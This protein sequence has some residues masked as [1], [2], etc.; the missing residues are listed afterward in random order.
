MSLATG[1]TL[2]P[3]TITAE[4]G[5]GGMG[6]VYTA[7]D[8]RLDRQVAIKVLPPDLT[9]DETA[10]QRFLQE[11]KAASALDHPNICTIFEINETDDGQLYL[12]MAHYEGETLKERIERGA[13]AVDHAVDIATQVGQGLAEAHGAGIVHRDVKPANLLIATNGVVKILDFGLAKLAGTEGVTQTGT[14]VGTVAYMSPE[15]ARGE[16][17]DHRTDIWSLGVVLYE[18]L[19]GT[20]PFQ[21][22]NL[23]A[24]SNAIQEG[25]PSSL[26]GASSSA[27]SVV[28]RA[29][30]A[31]RTQR[32]QA[33]T[34]LLDELRRETGP[35]TQAASPSD[36]PSIAVLPFANMSADPEQEYSCD[37]LAEEL[38]DT[39]ARLEGLKVVARTSAF[40]FKG[41]ADDIRRIGEQLDVA[42]VLEGS[43]RKAGNRLRITAQLIS[44]SDG[45]HLWS[46]RYDRTLDD[47]FAVQEEIAQAIVGKLKVELVGEPDAPLV[48]TSTTNLKAYS[49]H[50][51]GQ[52]HANRL[53]KSGYR[54]AL[55]CFDRA[56]AIEPDYAAAF[57]GRAFVHMARS[58][59][60]HEKPNE[61]VPKAREAAE[62]ALALD[63]E[64]A[65][66]VMSLAVQRFW[67]DWDWVGAERDFQ[68]AIAL[69]P[70]SADA[71]TLYA[72]FLSVRGRSDEA[73]AAAERSLELDPLSLQCNR[74]LAVALLFAGRLDAAAEQCR[75][76]LDLEPSYFPARWHLAQ[77]CAASGRDQD[78]VSVLEAGR[79]EAKGDPLL[80]AQLG[81]FYALT[82]RVAEARGI[83]DAL[84]R[85]RDAGYLPA[86]LIGWVHEGLD[87]PDKALA[88]YEQSYR[89]R[90]GLCVF[91]GLGRTGGWR[92]IRGFSTCCAGSRRARRSS[93]NPRF[94]TLLRRMNFPE[95]ASSEPTWVDVRWELLEDGLGRPRL[96]PGV[97]RR[98]PVDHH[99]TRAGDCGR[100]VHH[101][102]TLLADL[103]TTRTCAV[104][105]HSWHL[106]GR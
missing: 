14:T 69:S 4:L 30:H 68:R 42:T 54:R 27:Q 70:G 74:I 19:A 60:G 81:S 55:E 82:G 98:G 77:A 86:L 56:L 102:R 100:A 104:Y 78:A 7:Q 33:V 63:P 1:S 17:V 90:D 89:D 25:T 29:L 5:H 31:S 21:G 23:L 88:W 75:K 26:S 2:G 105:G 43:V 93:T 41:K 28:T 61:A 44:V 51:Q 45:Y 97:P 35:A 64:C 96:A 85:R 101:W 73:I 83:L 80:E 12:V 59:L 6:V 67:Y 79:D 76:T 91:F 65:E 11:A 94:H 36:V 72:E 47:V 106:V 32:Y 18:M 24:L 53:A 62:R 38:I 99:L 58:I 15:Q 9:R 34:D 16:E 39:L 22:E 10:K 48:K 40:K 37:G 20:P 57:A 95:T 3:Y 66:A 84:T 8:P 13:L 87:E 71:H 52:H 49:L 46:E 103:G 92:A 50:L